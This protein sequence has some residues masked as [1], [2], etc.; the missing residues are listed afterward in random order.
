MLEAKP[1]LLTYSIRYNLM[2][3]IAFFRHS[4]GMCAHD[5]VLF[6]AQ[7]PAILGY[8]CVCVCVC[9]CVD[10]SCTHT[11]RHT[12]THTHRPRRSGLQVY[13]RLV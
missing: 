11:H 1:Q 3:K 8:R 2:P 5:L 9:V 4:I 6:V 12:H 10:V 7:D 13:C